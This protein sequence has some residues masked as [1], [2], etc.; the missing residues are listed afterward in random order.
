MRLY[1]EPEEDLTLLTDDLGLSIA[2]DNTQLNTTLES[3][4]GHMSSYIVALETMDMLT[5]VELDDMPEDAVN[6]LL[7]GS[8]R[9]VETVLTNDEINEI[10]DSHMSIGLS[11]A[12]AWYSVGNEAIV[13][14]RGFWSS[15]IDMLKTAIKI[16]GYILGFKAKQL[17]QGLDTIRKVRN[18]LKNMEREEV[19]FDSSIT[20]KWLDNVGT[21]LDGLTKIN[22]KFSI[23]DLNLK[24]ISKNTSKYSRDVT[25][26]VMD[27]NNV[28][29][30]PLPSP[31]IKSIYKG[32][33]EDILSTLDS[34]VK[35]G[36]K[37]MDSLKKLEGSVKRVT[38]TVSRA[39]GHG[40]FNKETIAVARDY[41][42]GV[43]KLISK[44]NIQISVLNSVWTKFNFR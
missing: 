36:Q 29:I 9:Y 20:K 16:I 12:S 39:E 3:I 11:S 10:L 17:R 31:E 25:E 35:T 14:R 1:I 34:V 40:D 23:Y 4:V 13:K 37:T 5:E 38:D 21:S 42:H 44:N 27:I 15:L 28:E 24:S 8:M 19:K 18:V 33:V 30:E 2:N 32:A 6:T 22:N 43:N 7:R 26:M 41:I